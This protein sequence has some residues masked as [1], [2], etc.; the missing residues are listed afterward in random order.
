MKQQE[1]ETIMIHSGILRGKIGAAPQFDAGP[2][3]TRAR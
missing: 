3:T 2:S 1:Q